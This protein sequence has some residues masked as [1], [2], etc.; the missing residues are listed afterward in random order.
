MDRIDCV[1]HPSAIARIELEIAC[2]EALQANPQDVGVVG[3]RHAPVLPGHPDHAGLADAQRGRELDPVQEV[4]VPA[5]IEQLDGQRGVVREPLVGVAVIADIGGVQQPQGPAEEVRAALALA[6]L[7]Q[8]RA[9]RGHPVA[10][11]LD[12]AVMLQLEH[13]RRLPPDIRE[14]AGAADRP[15]AGVAREVS[16]DEDAVVAVGD[17]LLHDVAV[18]RLPL[19]Q[20]GERVHVVVADD[21]WRHL[22]VLQVQVHVLLARL[23]AVLLAAARVGVS[24]APVADAADIDVAQPRL[25]VVARGERPQEVLQLLQKDRIVERRLPGPVR[26][27]RL[28]VAV[29]AP[30]GS[31][32]H[33]PFRRGELL[34][35]A[36][37]ARLLAGDAKR[38]PEPVTDPLVD[39]AVD[40]RPVEA[41]LLR[42]QIRPGQPDVE[43]VHT[44]EL[45]QV[46]P[47]R[48]SRTC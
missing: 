26:P 34:L 37:R 15:R 13:R 1:G 29:V 5:A 42:L 20:V 22:E 46:C 8:R 12:A 6:E 35:D 32:L 40:D 43:V 36:V 44:R 23:V 39:Q 41:P 16:V 48:G 17:A 28:A 21:Q 7:L 47:P 4:P 18:Q 30:L 3:G 10:L 31:G 25:A 14:E 27:D 19:L 24:L 2:V 11:P 38:D 33:H 45:Q 9:G